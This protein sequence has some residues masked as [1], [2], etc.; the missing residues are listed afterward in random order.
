MYKSACQSMCADDIKAYAKL[1]TLLY[2]DD[3]VIMA[4]SVTEL[5]HALH[6]MFDYCTDN[7]LTVNANKTKVMVFSKGKIRNLP[8]LKYGDDLLEVVF[9]YPDRKSV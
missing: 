5:Q 2:A 3:T 8:V 9:S 1:C 7:K 6:C 4:E